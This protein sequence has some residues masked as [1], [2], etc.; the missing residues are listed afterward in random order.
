PFRVIRINARILLFHADGQG[1]DFLLAETVE[2]AHHG[3]TPIAF[4][5]GKGKIR[6]MTEIPHGGA[7][8]VRAN[9][10]RTTH[11]RMGAVLYK[12]TAPT[13]LCAPDASSFAVTN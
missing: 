12:G 4:Y 8:G 5:S 7:V 6:R 9:I 11:T 10:K 13:R 3:E 2:V 1:E